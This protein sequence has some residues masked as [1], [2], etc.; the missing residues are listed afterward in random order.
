MAIKIR[1]KTDQPIDPNATEPPEVVGEESNAL[2][3]IGEVEVSSGQPS[4]T[5]GGAML[6]TSAPIPREDTSPSQETEAELIDAGGGRSAGLPPI[7]GAGDGLQLSGLPSAPGM[8]PGEWVRQNQKG[9]MIGTG[10]IL[11]VVAIFLIYGSVHEQSRIDESD[12]LTAAL[13]VYNKWTNA[14][15][16]TLFILPQPIDDEPQPPQPGGFFPDSKSR[17]A[18]VLKQTEAALSQYPDDKITG[19]A[20]LLASSSAFASEQ[21]KKGNDHLS[22]AQ[23]KLAD[24]DKIF[25]AQLQATQHQEQKEYQK[26]IDAL[27]SIQSLSPNYSAAVLEDIAK[28]YLLLDKKEEAAKQYKAL[29]ENSMYPAGDKPLVRIKLALLV[30]DINSYLGTSP[31][32]AAPSPSP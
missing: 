28:L 30:D 11:L 16:Q 6:A 24:H 18:E 4:A 22:K 7:G 12:S 10:T 29:L 25:A 5:A 19:V 13:D 9:M 1:K 8:S 21:G 32:A 14:E 15:G 27:K 26:A 17:Q 23:A 2:S 20:H 31:E 3:T